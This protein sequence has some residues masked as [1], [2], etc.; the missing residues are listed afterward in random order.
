MKVM[1]TFEDIINDTRMQEAIIISYKFLVPY[2]IMKYYQIKISRVRPSS[3][4]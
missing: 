4:I 2:N 1:Q 3:T